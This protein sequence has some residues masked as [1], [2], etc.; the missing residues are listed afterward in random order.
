MTRE[1][2]ERSG[3]EITYKTRWHIFNDSHF[4]ILP[5]NIPMYLSLFSLKIQVLFFTNCSYFSLQ[6][7]ESIIEKHNQPNPQLW[8]TATA[9]TSTTQLLYLCLWDTS[10]RVGRKVLRERQKISNLIWNFCLLE[11]QNL[12]P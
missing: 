6:H 12:Y 11:C 10:R 4:P 3:K 2:I 8:I 7:K 1:S 5:A 9:S